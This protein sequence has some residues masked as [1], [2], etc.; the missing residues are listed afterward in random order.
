MNKKLSII[1]NDKES[2]HYK[3]KNMKNGVK[4][5]ETN[6]QKKLKVLDEQMK[7]NRIYLKKSKQN[8]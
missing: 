7:E 5:R 6:I 1:E 2:V 8:K 3:I 4:G